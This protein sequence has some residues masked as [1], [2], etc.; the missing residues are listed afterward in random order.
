MEQMKIEIRN[1][2]D[3]EL[4]KTILYSDNSTLEEKHE[5]LKNM[6]EDSSRH[7]LILKLADE[8]YFE[9]FCN[10]N[11]R[12][13]YLKKLN[14]EI[15]S[16]IY[17]KAT[18]SN[19]INFWQQGLL[20]IFPDIY[21]DDYFDEDHNKYPEASKWI[22]DNR[23][24][25]EYLTELLF[26]ILDRVENIED[27]KTF[28]KSFNIIELLI[29]IDSLNAKKILNYGNEFYS[30]VLWMFDLF[31][32][33]NFDIL[34]EKFIYFTPKQQVRIIK[35]IF[36]LKSQEK[37]DL[38]ISQLEELG[39]TYNEKINSETLLD[40]STS[41]IIKCLKKY[42]EDGNFLIEGELLKIVLNELGND[43]TKR[44]QIEDYFENCLG[45][46]VVG[47][48]LKKRNGVVKK[49]NNTWSISFDYNAEFIDKVKKLPLRRYDKDSKCWIIPI[50]EEDAVKKFAVENRFFI[51]GEANIL[52]DNYHLAEFHRGKLPNGILFCEGR[53]VNKPH[54]I[55]NKD[56]WWCNG[57]ACFLK[58]ETIHHREEW[59]KYT[60]LDFCEILELNTNE[61][62]R[63]G[64]PIPKGKYYQFISLI[65]RFNRLLG[66]L[67]CQDCNE[68][69]YPVDVSHF[70][71]YNVVRFRCANN[72]CKN[73]DEIYLNHCLNGQ[74]NAIIDSR[75][76]KTCP[77]GLYI[78][79]ECGSCC[80]H[81]FF[82]RRLIS[83]EADNLENSKKVWIYNDIKKKHDNKLGHLER[84]KY[85]CY[86]CGKEMEETGIDYFECFE[87]DIHYD[88]V[89]YKFKR[90]FKI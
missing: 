50:N 48:N 73:K 58:C 23:I 42:S 18:G 61:I 36:L 81:S 85:F 90:P 44:F 8:L 5:F 32:G 79:E 9:G 57:Q 34:K 27:R 4:T 59:E 74:C 22:K 53:M 10:D 39:C 14:S 77:N 54:K 21:F 89:K 87:C 12:D 29:N 80:S 16:L 33:L 15:E 35:K 51:E 67:Y 17:Q 3:Y 46:C 49:I 6:T 11:D 41:I 69:L 66:K 82:E 37:L 25:Q 65:N 24:T 78:C 70:A 62:N 31:A 84:S 63:M 20:S 55:L 68:I 75:V 52:S 76:S 71:A 56:Y 30:L 88:T 60:L 19:V 40:L 47:F 45:R 26:N 38:T 83:L 64:D 28:Q 7:E 86:K 43:K 13:I 2:N 72:K 1:F